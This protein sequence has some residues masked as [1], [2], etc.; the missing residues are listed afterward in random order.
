MSFATRF[1]KQTVVYWGNP[2]PDGR[3]GYTWDDPVELDCR[4]E[5]AEQMM[6]G[7]DGEEQLV[8]AR[9]WVDQDVDEGGYMYL[10]SLTDSV[11]DSDTVPTDL[12]E[13]WK[14]VSFQKIPRLNSTTDFI[15]KAGL[16]IAS[17]Q[18]V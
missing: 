14:I 15:R 9:V 2:A 12:D 17:R 7:G 8:K 18:T 11:L 4:W 5:K 10:G 16:N 3:G 1:L 6:I 13:A